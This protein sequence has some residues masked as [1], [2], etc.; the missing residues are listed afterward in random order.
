MVEEEPATI[1]ERHAQTLIGAAVLFIS[2]VAVAL[3]AW[4][5]VS[6]IDVRER[7]T[8]IEAL[9]V[10]GLESDVRQRENDLRQNTDT[11]ALR[12]R[13]REVELYLAVRGFRPPR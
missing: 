3:L 13:I 10:V 2:S 7:L 12:M 8:R 1:F 4:T 6:M 5:A 9:K 11:E